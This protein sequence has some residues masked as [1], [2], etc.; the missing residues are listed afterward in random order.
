M[1]LLFTRVLWKIVKVAESLPELLY[2]DFKW[3]DLFAVSVDVVGFVKDDDRIV[4]IDLQLLPY[5]R[6][7]DVL[8]RQNHNVS[9][10]N[11]AFGQ[12]VRTDSVLFTDL[13]QIFNV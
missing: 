2:L 5:L 8:V 6:G 10:T 12:V 13:H 4:Q 1:H 7:Q 9:S 3:K 11:P